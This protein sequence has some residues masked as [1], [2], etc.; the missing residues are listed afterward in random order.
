MLRGCGFETNPHLYVSGVYANIACVRNKSLKKKIHTLFLGASFLKGSAA[1]ALTC[2]GVHVL[3]GR[4]AAEHIVHFFQLR[5]LPV[6]DLAK[7]G[8]CS[9]RG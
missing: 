1:S 3:P 8:R 2:G 5:V 9:G 4:R 6:G 7:G